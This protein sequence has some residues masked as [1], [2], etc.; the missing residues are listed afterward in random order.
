MLKGYKARKEA[1]RLEAIEWQIWQA[2]EAMS[3]GEVAFWAGYFE[4]LGRRFGLLRE[5][6]A[7]GIC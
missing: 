1:A 3:W 5:F 4:K 7:E 2:G 6:R